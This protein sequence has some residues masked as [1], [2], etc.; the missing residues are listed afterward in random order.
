MYSNEK[1]T[2]KIIL[3]VLVTLFLAS[4]ATA[5]QVRILMQTSLLP[6]D[7]ARDLFNA[8]Q[9]SFDE[10]R[11]TDA[12]N[13]FR[14]VVRRFPRNAIADRADYYLIRTLAQVGKKNEALARI[15]AFGRQY[16]KSRWLDDVQ[17]LRIQLT[18]QIPP[19]AETYLLRTIFQ[20]PPQPPTP[21]QPA[22]SPFGN[23]VQVVGPF[24]PTPI[25]PIPPI[26]PG[27]VGPFSFGF[28]S[29]SSDP[30]ISLQQEIM[31]AMFRNNVNRAIE[32]ANERLKADPGDPVVLSS[33]SVVASSQ[34]AQALSMLLGIVRNS[35]NA[36]ARRDAIFWLGQ[37]RG[38]NDAI[39]D[40]LIGL[41]PS[42]GDDDSEAVTYT[43]S[44]IRSDKSINALTSIARDKNKSEKARTNAIFWIG[45]T[46]AAN[47][48]GLLEDIYKNSMD[49]SRIRQQVMYALS[50]TGDPQAVKIM[51]NVAQSDPDIDV[52][53]Q[54][55]FW[56]GQNRSP[57][58]N[59]ALERLLQRK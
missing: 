58:A 46:R 57:E 41:L 27:S 51:G 18:N 8:G 23:S 56:L 4:G 30:E 7:E 49:N 47:R 24:G 43:L 31:R 40:T 32:I 48:L 45:Q 3:T 5:Q 28:E 13:K 26:P 12:E 44:R 17:E 16:P 42:L 19:T 25:P 33:L 37:T 39:V 22:P 59:Q 14:E 35:P 20:Q 9:R 50:R 52:R 11:F 34:S 1:W 55:V 6:P 36:R 54:A 15:N 10:D 53:K 2:S 38:D 21:P 29:Q